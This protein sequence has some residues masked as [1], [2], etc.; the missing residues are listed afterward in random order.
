MSKLQFEILDENGDAIVIATSKWVVINTETRKIVHIDDNIMTAYEMENKCVFEE[1]EL[2]KLKEPS[3]FEYESEYVIKNSDVDFVGHVHNLNY[4]D[5]AYNAFPENVYN[6]RPF[7]KFRISYKKEIKAGEKIK[8]KY[9][10]DDKQH[11]VCL[12]DEQDKLHS[13]ISMR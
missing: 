2:E 1:P 12:F 5:L 4:I 10:C 9:V 3:V 6:L 11:I 13:I 8:C 7:D